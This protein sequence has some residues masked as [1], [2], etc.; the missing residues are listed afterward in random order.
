MTREES[1]L[2][3]SHE[4]K[5]SFKIDLISHIPKQDNSR[6][7]VDSRLLDLAAIFSEQ[8]PRMN[9]QKIHYKVRDPS[10]ASIIVTSGSH[11]IGG[12]MFRVHNE[13]S[14]VELILLGVKAGLKKKGI[15]SASILKLKEFSQAN[16]L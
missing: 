2:E 14:M 4:E 7:W 6:V 16:G 3:K 9:C 10:Y 8:L 13:V 5:N 12:C 1:Q 15:G 11:V